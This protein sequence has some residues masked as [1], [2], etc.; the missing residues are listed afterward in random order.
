L[1]GEDCEAE[2]L[3]RPQ[4]VELKRM[5]LPQ[6]RG[7]LRSHES[8]VGDLPVTSY[9]AVPVVSRNGGVIGGLFFGHA[10]RG[11]FPAALEKIMGGVAAMVAVAIDNARLL[12]QEQRARAEAEAASRAKEQ[13]LA[14]LSHELRTPLKRSSGRRI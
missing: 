7:Y 11:M 10:E 8:A 6:F 9:L 12:E 14:V 5:N 1:P 2:K 3:V 4:R 13:F